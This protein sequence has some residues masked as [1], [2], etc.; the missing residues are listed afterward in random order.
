MLMNM[1]KTDYGFLLVLDKGEKIIYSLIRFC[2]E[3][4][5]ESGAFF[6]IGGV[7]D[8][9]LGFYNETKGDYE[10]R[11]FERQLEV[12][13][14]SGNIGVLDEEPIIHA[15]ISLGKEDFSTLGGHLIEATANPLLE[16]HVLADSGKTER[17]KDKNTILKRII[18]DS[19]E[20]N[21][22]R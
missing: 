1:K 18:I 19:K 9:E 8:A 22:H 7:R 3:K 12:L 5:F 13:N 20:G 4:K 21:M 10:S 14:I 2:K 11:S 15:H 17:I 6:G 16:V